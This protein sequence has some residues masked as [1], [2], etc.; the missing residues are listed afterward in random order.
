MNED[1]TVLLIETT[2]RLRRRGGDLYVFNLHSKVEEDLS[3]FNPK[4]YLSVARIVSAPA[5]FEPSLEEDSTEEKRQPA[6]ASVSSEASG[7]RKEI[8]EIEISFHEDQVYKACD[9]V[10]KEA[11]EMGFPVNEISRIKIAVYEACLNAIQHSNKAGNDNNMTVQVEKMGDMLQINVFDRGRGF[12]VDNTEE[13]DVTEAASHR[14]TG[15]MGLH[16]IRKAMDKVDYKMNP[17]L[18]NRLMMIKYLKK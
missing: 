12:L 3:L 10:I 5:T 16:I 11:N 6:T 8:S 18:G 9:F 1:L 4:A 7:L 15:G 2:A 17:I 14:K 13:Y